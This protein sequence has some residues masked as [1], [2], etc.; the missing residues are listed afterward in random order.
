M[1]DSKNWLQDLEPEDV[2]FLKRFLL[3]SGSLKAVAKEYGISYPTVRN[4]LDRLIAKV[5]ALDT[6]SPSDPFRRK[7]QAMVADGVLPVDRARELLDAF[8]AS[9]QDGKGAGHAEP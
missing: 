4:R 9:K 3:A 6:V 8:E 7:L 2:A 1:E 5:Q